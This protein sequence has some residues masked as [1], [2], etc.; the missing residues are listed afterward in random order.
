MSEIVLPPVMG[1]F[2]TGFVLHLA[3]AWWERRRVQR[4]MAQVN[5]MFIDIDATIKF[6]KWG[7]GEEI[8]V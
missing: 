8:D 2:C 6:V 3:W 1:M 4:A 7:T 5:L